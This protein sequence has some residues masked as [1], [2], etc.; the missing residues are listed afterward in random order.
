VQPLQLAFRQGVE[1]DATNALLG[2]RALQ[3]TKEN[4]GSTGI[5]D[6]RLAQPTL[7]LRVRRGLALTAGCAAPRLESHERDS[8]RQGGA[9]WHPACMRT[10]EKNLGS[11]GI[12][13][14]AL[15]QTTLDLGVRR[16]LPLSAFCTGQ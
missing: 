5:G 2:T 12:G 9:G 15:A 11:T 4:L 10:T 13:N 8:D 14:P 16:G 1:V 3:P 7:D 6:C